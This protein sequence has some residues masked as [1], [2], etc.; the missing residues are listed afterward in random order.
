[1]VIA[2]PGAGIKPMDPLKDLFYAEN[3]V[4]RF[5]MEIHG[6]RP[7]LSAEDYKSISQSFG[8]GNNSYLVNGLD[9]KDNYY[10]KKVYVSMVRVVDFLTQLPQW[11]GK[12]VMAQGNS[13]GRTGFNCHRT[14]QTH[15]SLCHKPPR[16]ERHGRIQSQSCRRLSSYIYQVQR[17]GY[18]S[19]NKHP[20]LL[21]CSEFRIKNHCCLSL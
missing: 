6:I 21:R 20:Q 13:Q 7:D 12:N 4:I 3:D 1:M 10:M 17:Y 5:D 19:K 16:P 9:D 2:P 15:Y 11:D 18:T 8:N 14:R